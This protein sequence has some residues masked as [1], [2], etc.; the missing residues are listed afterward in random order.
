MAMTSYNNVCESSKRDIM[1]C[2][3]D[4]LVLY[5]R[6]ER[7]GCTVIAFYFR[8]Y[9]LGDLSLDRP[10]AYQV[11]RLDF[12]LQKLKPCDSFA[13]GSSDFA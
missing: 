6:I 4:F 9:L 12:L 10:L 7:D 3:L 1:T 11:S 13:S 8:G 5:C 2:S